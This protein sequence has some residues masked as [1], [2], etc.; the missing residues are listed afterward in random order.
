M[1]APHPM[2]TCMLYGG[3]QGL[4]DALSKVVQFL[5]QDLLKADITARLGASS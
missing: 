2:L 5:L 1:M 3:I 4:K